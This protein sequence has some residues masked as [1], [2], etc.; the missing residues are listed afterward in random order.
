MLEAFA[1]RPRQAPSSICAF[2]CALV[3]LLTGYDLPMLPLLVA[4]ETVDKGKEAEGDSK[5]RFEA[6]L[7][8]PCVD[9]VYRYLSNVALIAR[10]TNTCLQLVTQRFT[11]ST[12][13]TFSTLCPQAVAW[14]ASLHI[15][16]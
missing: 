4:A 14:V 12:V 5:K 16:Y 13:A 8:T 11:C 1:L 6:R 9:G 7:E 15:S 2:A 10:R 3:T